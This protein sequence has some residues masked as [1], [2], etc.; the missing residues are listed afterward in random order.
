MNGN[1]PQNLNELYQTVGFIRGKI[2]GIDTKLSS[3]CNKVEK[4]EDSV[5][6]SKGKTAGIGFAAGFIGGV[7]GVIVGVLGFFKKF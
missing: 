1:T 3:Y 4:L 5:A 2:E 6:Y 7:V